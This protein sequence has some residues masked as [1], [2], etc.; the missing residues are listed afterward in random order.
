MSAL[1]FAAALAIAS[2]ADPPSC[3]AATATVTT[4]ER[5]ASRPSRW[6][7]RCVQVSGALQYSSL[8][9]G[10]RGFYRSNV[11]DPGSA[12]LEGDLRHRIGVYGDLPWPEKLESWTVVG[13]V[14]SCE[15]RG[16]EAQREARRINRHH[17]ASGSGMVYVFFLSGYCHYFPGA[18]LEAS[19]FSRGADRPYYRLVGP[20]ARRLYGNLAPA[21]PDWRR[22]RRFRQLAEEFLRLLQEGDEQGLSALHGR[23]GA[24]RADLAHL[25]SDRDSPFREIRQRNSQSYV[26]F[27][28]A[29]D[30]R[31]RTPA[32]QR[33]PDVFV[34]YCRE[35][36]CEGR[37][38]I[39]SVDLGSSPA[40]PYACVS[41]FED[42]EGHVF[43][44]AVRREAP[45]REPPETA[46]R[47]TH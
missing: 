3:T 31:G 1:G 41:I 21:R 45:L 6:L 32:Q 42:G 26:I 27:Y 23:F 30:R 19:E 24:S 39:S 35:E 36:S 28:Q 4:V 29:F 9:S 34:C 20:A 44:A 33:S 8:F 12:T 2:S 15:R 37:W 14:D 43:M 10:V 38:P 7:G 17:Q 11:R 18:V 16:R 46:F 13:R 5:I 40:H 22:F 47:G 25:L